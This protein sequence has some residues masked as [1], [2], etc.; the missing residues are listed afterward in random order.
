MELTAFTAFCLIGLPT[1][2]AYK[3]G[4]HETVELAYCRTAVG[5]KYYKLTHQPLR[6]NISASSANG[7]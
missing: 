2:L 6:A 1:Q 3:L 4:R 7:G 5:Q